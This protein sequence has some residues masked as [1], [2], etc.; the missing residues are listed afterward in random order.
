VVVLEPQAEAATAEG[1]SEEHGY[2]DGAAGPR[3]VRAIYAGTL[4]TL[5][6][7]AKL[8]AGAES[9]LA[10]AIATLAG[11]PLVASAIVGLLWHA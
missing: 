1:A 5:E 6:D 4:A 11:T 10:L 3:R 9:A 8:R 2:R 7:D